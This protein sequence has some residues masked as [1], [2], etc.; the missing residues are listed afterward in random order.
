MEYSSPVEF[1]FELL[2]FGI[3]PYETENRCEEKHRQDAQD[4]EQ[5]E[6]H[7]HFLMCFERSADLL[8]PISQVVEAYCKTRAMLTSPFKLQETF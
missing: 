4:H 5:S 6:M 8:Y 2:C 3:D 7:V 1:I